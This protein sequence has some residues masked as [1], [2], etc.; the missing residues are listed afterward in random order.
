MIS[1][2]SVDMY[3]IIDEYWCGISMK[4]ADINTKYKTVDKK[5]KPVAIPL[6]EDSWQKMKEVANDPSLRDPKTIV[7]NIDSKSSLRPLYIYISPRQTL[8]I[9]P[10]YKE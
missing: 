5:I 9:K 4:E 7:M 3:T 8:D 6:P 2:N 10:L 1:V